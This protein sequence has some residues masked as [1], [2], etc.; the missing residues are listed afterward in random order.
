MIS[1]YHHFLSKAHLMD[2]LMDRAMGAL[3]APRKDLA[4]RSMMPLWNRNIATGRIFQYYHGATGAVGLDR[5]EIRAKR[6][7]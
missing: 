6:G 4:W 1:L 5:V 2:A 7:F 3:P